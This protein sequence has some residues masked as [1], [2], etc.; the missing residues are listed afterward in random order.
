LLLK[1]PNLR[2]LCFDLL[3]DYFH[4]RF[5][6]LEKLGRSSTFLLCLKEPLSEALSLAEDGRVLFN[7][8]AVNLNEVDKEF[9]DGL[10]VEI[11]Q[12]PAT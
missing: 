4:L 6:V 12:V 8:F 10:I 2:I 7:N 9:G 11:F 1:I 3:L 5:K